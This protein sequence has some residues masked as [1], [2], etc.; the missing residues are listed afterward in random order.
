M[1]LHKCGELAMNNLVVLPIIIPVICGLVLVI[2]RKNIRLHRVVS[3]LAMAMLA[4]VSVSLVVDIKA[5]GIQTLQAGGWQAPFGISLVADMFAALLV[6]AAS[7]VGLFCLLYAVGSIGAG[8]EEHYFYPLF[9]FL[10][11]G[12][13]GSF[14]TGDIFNLFVFFE[15][16]LIASYVLI[17]LGGTRP[18]LREAIPYVLIN[19]VS[20]SLFLLAVAYLYGLTGT[21]N[22]AHLSV[23]VAELGQDGL[24]T[25]VSLLF[26]FVFSIKAG[27]FLFF[28]L[29]GAY[30]APPTA[31]AATFAALLTK[32]GI[33]AIFRMF[34]LVFYHEPQITHLFIG[35]LSGATMVLGAAGAVAF[36]DI[37][38]ILTYNVVVGA[39][40]IMAGLASF[41]L[42][43]MMGAVFYLIHDIVGKALI[44]LLGGTIIYLTG[45]SKLNGVSGLIRTH[46]FLGWMFFLA[47]LSL[48]GIP[49][50]SGFLGKIYISRGT[51]EADYFWLGAIGLGTSLLVLYSLMKVFMN[52][53]WG[54]TYWSKEI[55]KGSTEGLMVPVAGL[56]VLMISLGLGT[57]GIAAFVRLAAEGLMN[58]HVYIDAVLIR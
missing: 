28:W 2:F 54:E 50:L 49:P 34:T 21:L 20:S 41:T 47:S 27:L 15:V 14:L 5:N 39:G 57:E 37:K 22:L 9:L 11:A 16:M 10:L 38:K 7:I 13:N 48:A 33:Y 46:P 8:R 24:M 36:K 58:P 44:F 6:L 23:R 31:I 4:V 51:F 40:F 32:V 42:M 35:V 12:V 18:Q 53:F 3:I 17:S 1:T 55:E 30:S 25:T 26:L 56:T 52:V 45:T 43:G 19:V 29:P